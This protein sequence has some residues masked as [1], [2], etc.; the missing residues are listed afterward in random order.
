MI[1]LRLSVLEELS[2]R[3]ATI[4]FADYQNMLMCKFEEQKFLSSFGIDN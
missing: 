4:K 2:V 1:V 3:S